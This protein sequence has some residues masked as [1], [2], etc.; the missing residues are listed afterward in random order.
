MEGLQK[1][2]FSIDFRGGG[3]INKKV[4]VDTY[5]PPPSDFSSNVL[6][7]IKILIIII[8]ELPFEYNLVGEI[9]ICNND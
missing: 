9:T 3:V 1:I 6:N 7:Q 8:I 5:H 2:G 4:G